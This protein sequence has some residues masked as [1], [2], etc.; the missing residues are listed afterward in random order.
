ML[1][2]TDP[3]AKRE[4]SQK[5]STNALAEIRKNLVEEHLCQVRRGRAWTRALETLR[6]YRRLG[7]LLM[8]ILT[9]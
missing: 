9:S 7:R 1:I 5:L 4:G 6:W 8:A 3:L 2:G